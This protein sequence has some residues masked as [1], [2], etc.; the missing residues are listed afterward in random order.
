[1]LGLV[2]CKI[3]HTDIEVSK[4]SQ[5]QQTRKVMNMVI[6]TRTK[7]EFAKSHYPKAINIPFPDKDF[8]AKVKDNLSKNATDIWIMFMIVQDSES[9]EL[10]KEN[11][12]QIYK[13]HKLFK[14]P[15]AIY[16]LQGGFEELEKG[17]K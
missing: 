4:F 10:L 13:R 14:G 11:L 3:S 17:N 1:M 8:K 16:Y 6:D 12:K 2:S 7:E 15:A 5:Y 9:T